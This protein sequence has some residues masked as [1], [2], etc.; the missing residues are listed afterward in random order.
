MYKLPEKKEIIDEDNPVTLGIQKINA[1]LK[2]L[3]NKITCHIGPWKQKDKKTK[4]KKEDLL[5]Q[6]PDD[7]D[8]VESYVYD[9]KRFLTLGKTGY[10]R[11]NI[12]YSDD[13][14]ISEI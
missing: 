7:V 12:F 9:F 5:T 8:F 4:L 13:T 1:M 2:A 3:T 14:N 11:I 6:L 10:V